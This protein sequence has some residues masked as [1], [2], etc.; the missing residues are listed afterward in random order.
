MSRGKVIMDQDR[1]SRYF[2]LVASTRKK[3]NNIDR[4][5]MA[6]SEDGEWIEVIFNLTFNYFQ[7]DYN[8][9]RNEITGDQYPN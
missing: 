1:N 9:E 3:R 4:I 2:H 6:S 7:E 8:S 5:K